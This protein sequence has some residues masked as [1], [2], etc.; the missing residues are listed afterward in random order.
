MLRAVEELSAIINATSVVD[1]DQEAQLRLR[2]AL[3]DYGYDGC[4][5]DALIGALAT[6][7]VVLRVAR[8]GCLMMLYIRAGD[9]GEAWFSVEPAGLRCLYNH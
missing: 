4:V 7:D 5:I 2:T 8:H 3:V 6:G 1:N 9:E